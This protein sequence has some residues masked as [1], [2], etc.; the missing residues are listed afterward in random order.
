MN[1]LFKSIELDSNIGQF[2][3]KITMTMQWN[4]IE[5]ENG[6]KRR[7]KLTACVYFTLN[8]ISNQFEFSIISKVINI[9][10]VS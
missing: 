9:I 3:H 10:E 8:I 4:R 2:L 5:I 6:R 1:F 7:N